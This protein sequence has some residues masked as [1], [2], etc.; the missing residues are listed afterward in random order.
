MSTIQSPCCFFLSSGIMWIWWCHVLI[1]NLFETLKCSVKRLCDETKSLHCWKSHIDLLTSVQS[2][3][4]LPSSIKMLCFYTSCVPY[5]FFFNKTNHT[6]KH[7][8]YSP[9]LTSWTINPW[10]TIV[11]V[12]DSG[13]FAIYDSFDI[14]YPSSHLYLNIQRGFQFSALPAGGAVVQ[15][16]KSGFRDPTRRWGFIPH[17]H[18]PIKSLSSLVCIISFLALP[19]VFTSTLVCP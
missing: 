3:L 10:K 18:F 15:T 8:V 12:S 17:F 11:Q 6:S 9:C 19:A 1:K 16:G 4:W 13:C 5:F 14:I 7:N 2:Y